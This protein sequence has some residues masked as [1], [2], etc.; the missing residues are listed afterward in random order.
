MKQLL[1]VALVAILS[2]A[3]C[4]KSNNGKESQGENSQQTTAAIKLTSQSS[5][6]MDAEGGDAVVTYDIIKQEGVELKV[7][8][9]NEALITNV[10]SSND[11]IITLRVTPNPTTELRE[12]ALL[13]SYGSS[14][15]SVVVK[16][17]GSS[18]ASLPTYT[19]N[20]TT[21]I[22]LYYAD[23]LVPGLGHYWVIL[24]NGGFDAQ[25]NVVP[26]GE[27]FRFDLLG[28][29]ASDL[30]N[31][32]IPDGTYTFDEFNQF[33]PYTILNLSNSDYLYVDNQMEGWAMPFID[34]T[35]KVE[36]NKFVLEA[37]VENAK[38]V[39]T[40]EG[41]YTVEYKAITEQLS[42][43]KSDVEIDL[44]NCIVYSCKSY[45]DNWAS[46]YCNWYIAFEDKEGY[47]QGTYL[48]LE[49]LT[50]NNLNG[51]SG[52]EGTY[53]AGGVSPN[54][55]TLPL[56]GEYTFVSGH[57]VSMDS[58]QIMGSL[59]QRYVGGKGIDQAPLRG[60]TITITANSDGTHTIVIDATDDATPANKLTLNWTGKLI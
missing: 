30:E 29:L 24:S 54:D 13:V 10:N 44:S 31:V 45:G 60:G 41:D 42:N 47:N 1:W 32:R 53:T 12:G 52:F 43:L 46:G 56:F 22:G 37:L 38:Y 17:E 28:P 25:G 20:A 49:L 9:V 33:A 34:A 7:T 39:V 36:G 15:F 14:S 2:L 27:F 4:E 48:A 16:Q 5:I 26:G 8:V 6:R 19:V 55:S 23:R 35:L 50:D 57:R 59:Y 11:G 58:S 3:S 40:Y 18:T 51:S 21:F